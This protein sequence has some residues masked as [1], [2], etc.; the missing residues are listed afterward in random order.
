MPVME[1]RE[2]DVNF[3]CKEIVKRI[4]SGFKQNVNILITGSLGTGKSSTAIRMAIICSELIAL[5]DATQLNPSTPYI[6]S[7]STPT[8]LLLR[9][10]ETS[11][12]ALAV[13]A[14]RYFDSDPGTGIFGTYDLDTDVFTPY[15][16]TGVQSVTGLPVDNTDTANPV[17]NNPYV[18]ISNAPNPGPA[19]SDWADLIAANGLVAGWTYKITGAYSNSAYGTMTALVMA[20]GANTINLESIQVIDESA[21]L[22]WYLPAKTDDIA[23]STVQIVGGA[24]KLTSAQAVSLNSGFL[25]GLPVYVD[26][27]GDQYWVNIVNDGTG[28]N[29]AGY[30]IAA[31][32]GEV[33]FGSFDPTFTTFTPNASV[34]APTATT[35]GTVVTGLTGIVSAKYSRVGNVLHYSFLVSQ[36]VFDFTAGNTGFVEIADTEFPFL[37]SGDHVVNASFSEPEVIASIAISATSLRINFINKSTTLTVTTDVSIIGQ[38][39]L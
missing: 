35:D 34:W 22:T 19:P 38:C 27:G 33:V 20:T 11:H 39:L 15:A 5:R 30:K 13:A 24:V 7:D 37:P 36:A 29:N 28:V 8:S 10:A 14:I 4:L 26:L 2:S 9:C 25:G 6:V 18:T 12:G 3:F 32:N 16:G 31:A 17:I 23:F 1:F 21:S